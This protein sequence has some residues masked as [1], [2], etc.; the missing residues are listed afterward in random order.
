MIKNKNT[1]TG[2][3]LVLG[4]IAIDQ[5]IKTILYYKY[6]GLIYLNKGIF[7]GFIDNALAV[8]FFLVS[9]FLIFFYLCKEQSQKQKIPLLLIAAG[10]FSNV[11]DRV[12]HGGVVDYINIAN[13]TNFNLADVYIIAGVILF[14]INIYKKQL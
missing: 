2:I 10:A 14:A 4:L 13:L 1:Y 11:C 3:F 7:F 9:G 5:A 6:P 12:W 8:I